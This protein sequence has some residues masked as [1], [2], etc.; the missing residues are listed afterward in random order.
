MARTNLKLMR[1]APSSWQLNKRSLKVP[2]LTIPYGVLTP[3]NIGTWMRTTFT[4]GPAVGV[5]MLKNGAN[6]EMTVLTTIW[7]A[8]GFLLRLERDSARLC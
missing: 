2:N 5:K 6:L 3:D 4:M 8:P 7:E 1:L